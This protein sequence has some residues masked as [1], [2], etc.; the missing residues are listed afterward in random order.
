ME[1]GKL[2]TTGPSPIY[3]F[4]I[5]SIS[6]DEPNPSRLQHYFVIS[7]LDSYVE[8][9]NF[10]CRSLCMPPTDGAMRRWHQVYCRVFG[11][12]T[13]ESFLHSVQTLPMRHFHLETSEAG[14]RAYASGAAGEPKVISPP[15]SRPGP[16]LVPEQ[17]I[18]TAP[19]ISRD[20]RLLIHPQRDG[21]DPALELHRIRAELQETQGQLRVEVN[22]SKVNGL[23]DAERTALLYKL[24]SA[25]SELEAEKLRSKE[26]SEKLR[27]QISMLQERMNKLLSN[28][29]DHLDNLAVTERDRLMQI[30][31]GYQKRE[32]EMREEFE[33]AVRERDRRLQKES[34]RGETLDMQLH[35]ALREIESLR[36]D[37]TRLSSSLLSIRGER[38][39][40]ESQ[41]KRLRLQYEAMESHRITLERD[42]S[43]W[44][45]EQ[46][47]SEGEITR[48][49]AEVARLK[50]ESERFHHFTASLQ[51]EL[52]DLDEESATTAELL[53]RKVLHQRSYGHQRH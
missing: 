40:E 38:E 20:T 43:K 32:L 52:K 36:E 19:L 3:Y 41:F 22:R 47:R 50:H 14:A 35:N 6:P 18:P 28:H 30:E 42:I 1:V 21:E 26:T 8:A 15:R 37:N 10:L 13:Y 7:H 45:E 34:S 29:E 4:I 12:V 49:R 27:T 44:E 39:Q 53:R 24:E 17:R 2:K 46:R 11:A 51:T 25:N 31:T 33:N 48:L 16:V 9:F 23:G 5:D